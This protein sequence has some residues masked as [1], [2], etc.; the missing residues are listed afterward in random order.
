[1]RVG[2]TTLAQNYMDWDRYEAEERGDEVPPRPEISDRSIFLEEVALAQTADGLG[3]DA[4]WTIEHHFTPYTMVTNPLQLLTYLAGTT[5]NVDLGTMVVV[6]PWH[7]PVRVAEDIVMLDSLLGPDRKVMCGVGRGLGRREYVGM[8]IDQN[9]ARGRFDESIEIIRQL[10]ATGRC[11]FHG[12]HYQIDNLHLRPQPDRDMS[13]CLFGAGGTSDTVG[14][15]A[16]NGI[17]PLTVPTVSLDIALKGARSFAEQRAA[18]GFE[19]AQNKLGLYVYCADTHEQARSGAEQYLVNF[20]DS[21]LRHYELGNDHFGA[22]KGYESYQAVSKAFSGDTN[23]MA[24]GYVNDHPWGTPAEVCERIKTI[25]AAF[26]ASELMLG[27]KYG[28]MPADV[29]ERSMR[30]FAEEVLPELHEFHTEPLTGAA[31]S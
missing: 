2:T 19:P 1:M 18:A 10:L 31:T 13:D 21:S 23:P 15:I 8:N 29:A 17:N 3:F 24:Q 12:E 26:G 30:L 4:L 22:I 14:L 20:A 6:A 25:A 9:D 16:E 28:G 27:F 5:Q 7:N 11:T